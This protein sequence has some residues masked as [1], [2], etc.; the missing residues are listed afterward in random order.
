MV[1][2]SPSVGE[3]YGMRL[4][5]SV[6]ERDPLKVSAQLAWQGG[7]GSKLTQVQ[8]AE[9]RGATPLPLRSAYARLPGLRPKAWPLPEARPPVEDKLQSGRPVPMTTGHFYFAST[10]HRK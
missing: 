2:V 7:E 6:R 3:P 1:V 9:R 8:A 10:V 5:T 4:F